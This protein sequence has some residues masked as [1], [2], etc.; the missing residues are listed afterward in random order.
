MFGKFKVL[1]VSVFVATLSGCAS[2]S[3]TAPEPIIQQADGLVVEVIRTDCEIN[4]IQVN[5]DNL[6][7]LNGATVEILALDVDQHTEAEF[8]CL[9]DFILFY[10]KFLRYFLMKISS[11]T[12][13]S[14]I[15][16]KLVCNFLHTTVYF[17]QFRILFQ[18][19]IFKFCIA[20][21]LFL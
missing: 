16:E 11:I 7:E 9:I 1:T 18:W 12:I 21:F 17:F 10:N 4:R 15:F 14:V 8:H 19:I 3:D 6:K 13:L 20:L 5:N 2:I